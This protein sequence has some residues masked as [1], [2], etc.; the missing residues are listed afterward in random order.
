M[1]EAI[2]YMF[3]HKEVVELLVKKQG[4]H[5]GVW[6][7]SLEIGQAAAS[8]PAPDGKSV[9]PAAISI[10]QRIGLKKHEGAPSNLTVDAAAVNPLSSATKKR[11]E[12]RATK[13]T[14]RSK[15]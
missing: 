14:K 15:K 3:D 4:L 6:M 1:A 10:V 13:A 2:Q 11:E 9:L 12:Q 5:E 7:L 8:V